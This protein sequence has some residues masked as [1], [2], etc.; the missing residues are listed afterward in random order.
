MSAPHDTAAA[1]IRTS[2]ETHCSHGTKYETRCID[3][4][5]VWYRECLQDA[6]RRVN[7]CTDM[8]TKLEREK[9]AKRNGK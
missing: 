4:E 3:C 6:A 8:I 7:S 2:V 1:P 9:N 5:I